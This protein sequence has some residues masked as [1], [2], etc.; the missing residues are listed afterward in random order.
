M[1]KSKWELLLLE[2]IKDA[3]LPTP[4][5]EYRFDERNGRK[6]RFDFAYPY[7]RIGIECHGSIWQQG[8]HNRGYGIGSDCEKRNSA[9]LQGWD[10]YEFVPEQINSMDAVRIIK[11]ALELKK[12]DWE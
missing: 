8:R 4:E 7:Q 9:Q 11:E 1:S 12:E 5:R 3:G 6:W 2:H 10:V